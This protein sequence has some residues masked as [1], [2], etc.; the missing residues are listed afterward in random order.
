MYFHIVSFFNLNNMNKYKILITFVIAISLIIFSLGLIRLVF[1]TPQLEKNI[2]NIVF[3]SNKIIYLGDSVLNADHKNKEFPSSLVDIFRNDIKENVLEIS[4]AAYTPFIYDKYA[5]VI[6]EYSNDTKLI[7]IPINLRAFSSSWYQFPQYQFHQECA[8]LSIINLRLNMICINEHI[9]NLIFS[10]RIKIKTEEFFEEI[11]TAKG[12][13]SSTRRSLF[14]DLEQDCSYEIKEN[15]T[16][17]CNNKEY[18]NQLIEYVQHGITLRQAIKVMRYNYH[19]AENIKDTNTSFLNIIN[20]AK[21]FKEGNIKVLFYVT[22]LDIESI[23]KFSGNIVTNIINDNINLLENSLKG[24][25]IYFL[26]LSDLLEKKHFE[27]ACACEHIDIGGKTKIVNNI[28][29][30]I[31]VKI[32]S[33]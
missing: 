7:I 31:K 27:E 24:N 8:Y 22:P 20:L 32:G 28:V 33:I 23:Q 17:S 10:E 9:K 12:F 16:Y 30:F 5:N 29:N 13:L 21:I 11:I 4:A 6:K 15:V 18:L 26:N 14:E 3:K 25:N 1:A 2:Y 19:Y